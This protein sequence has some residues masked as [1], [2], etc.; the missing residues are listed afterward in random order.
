MHPRRFHQ[1][2]IGTALGYGV[3]VGALSTIPF[4]LSSP[5]DGYARPITIA[6]GLGAATAFVTLQRDNPR[7]AI[8][9]LTGVLVASM[10]L[11]GGP[12]TVLLQLDLLFL[13]TIHRQ[14]RWKFLAWIAT[15]V[16]CVLMTA[17]AALIGGTGQMVEV[18]A[19]N[20]AL[21]IVAIWW[22]T[23]VR[24][25]T[26]QAESERR[27][28]REQELLTEKERELAAARAAVAVSAERVRL[29]HDMH[30]V[31]AGRLSAMSLLASQALRTELSHDRRAMLLSSL[32]D[33][34]NATMIEVRAMIGNLA[35]QDADEANLDALRLSL[36]ETIDVARSLGVDISVSQPS[37]VA[38]DSDEKVA[39]AYVLAQE[40][41]FN[42]ITHAAPCRAAL[43]IKESPEAVLLEAW[44]T[45]G[46][47]PH[48][49]SAPAHLHGRGLKNFRDRL[50]PFGGSVEFGVSASGETWQTA[51]RIP[52][53]VGPQSSDRS[54]EATVVR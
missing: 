30:D 27:R 13:A 45:I 16:S 24:R 19:Q 36:H 8:P 6:V 14:S 40:A 35:N 28:T 47:G 32:K 53:R 33:C 49:D 48:G 1:G 12:A 2:A 22:A 4:L 37:S 29:A 50:E 34:A 52:R 42:M 7:I 26:E 25:K 10:L 17:V 51:V 31:V 44:N 11:N 43:A 5:H 23:D 38:S 20:V 39:L 9:G 41:V 54:I 3:L 46:D 21:I 15:G 18:L